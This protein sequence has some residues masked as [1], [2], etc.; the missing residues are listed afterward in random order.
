MQDGLSWFGELEAADVEWILENAAEQQV[1]SGT[2]LTREG[3]APDALHVVLEGLVGVKL[4][5]MGGNFV[6]RLGPGEIVGEMSFLEGGVAAATVEAVESSL[7]LTLHRAKLD[8]KLAADRSF[9]ARLYRAF[10]VTL[11][12]RLRESNAAQGRLVRSKAAMDAA[13]QTGWARIADQL[14]G[15]KQLLAEADR[16]AIKNDDQVPEEIAARVRE[17]FHAFCHWLNESIGERS[18]EPVEVRHELGDRVQAE[19]LPYLILTKNGERWYSKPRGYAGDFLS[20]EWLYQDSAEGSGR[21]GPLLDRCFL[22]MDAARAVRNRRALLVDEIEKVMAAKTGPGPTRVL[23]MACG[24]ARELFDVYSKLD[25]PKKLAATCLDIDLQA[26]AFVG[27]IRDKRKL[28]SHMRLENGN[29]VYLAL[30]KQKLDLP[31]QDLIYSIGLIDY[32]ND[33]FVVRLLDYVHGILA[34]GGK[35]ILGNFHPRNPTKAIMD[36][37][38]DWRLIHRDEADLDRLFARS[39]LGHPCDAHRYEEQRVNLFASATKR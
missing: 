10:A 13:A 7:I 17:R 14:A 4:A 38:L 5:A 12:R 18:P 24:P 16:A 2:V 29:L 1:I 9:A 25:D 19:V 6:Q 23:S 37:V 8:E 27:D 31:P 35:V 26:L 15:F 20:I 33:D 22:E 11:S 30:G 21:L 39:K 34:P 28:K 3:E 32:F 36:H